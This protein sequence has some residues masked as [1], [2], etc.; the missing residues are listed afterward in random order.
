MH[1]GLRADMSA[2]VTKV[3]PTAQE[4]LHKNILEE[5]TKRDGWVEV[6]REKNEPIPVSRCQLLFSGEP[7]G[8]K[9]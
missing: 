2:V 8:L 4:S 1:A 6:A 5:E 7:S 3:C 9:I